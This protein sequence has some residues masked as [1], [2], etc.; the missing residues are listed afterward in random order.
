MKCF[1]ILLCSAAIALY[2]CSSNPASD[3]GNMGTVKIEAFDNT[4]ASDQGGRPG[5][6]PRNV[7][8]VN[9]TVR[10]VSVHNS[11][12][13]VWDTL[14]EPNAT[15][16][17]LDLINGATALLA[18]SPLAVGTYS[19]LRLVLSDSNEVV[20]DGQSHP[21]VVPSGE[22][23]GVKVNLGFS[24][25]VDE[26]VE[27]YIDFDVPRSVKW[28]PN[29]YSLRPTFKAFKKI[30]SGT[31]SGV[32]TDTSGAFVP[33]ASVHAVSNGD[34]TTT[35]TT[36]EGAFKFILLAGT[37]DIAASAESY[38]GA[39]TSYTGVQVAAEDTLPELLAL[40]SQPRVHHQLPQL[41]W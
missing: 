39:N 36:D 8:H 15:L 11:E 18:E 10:S 19:Q 28:N 25:Q 5:D 32:V 7:E 35:V 27:I 23:S 13:G 24:I 29:R 1:L 41:G 4:L 16:D 17:F 38:E 26:I 12:T 30:L 21:L 2:A 3:G 40:S 9:L 31:V 22:Q 14:A 20:I 33:N 37:Y 34:S 6:V